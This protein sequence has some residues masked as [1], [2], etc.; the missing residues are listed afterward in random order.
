LKDL[1]S[2]VK[3]GNSIVLMIDTYDQIEPLNNWMCDFTRQLPNN[4]FLVI[5]TCRRL[6][7]GT[8]WNGFEQKTYAIKMEE[9]KIE[10]LRELINKAYKTHSKY[11]SGKVGDPDPKQVE[12]I[13]VFARGIPVIAR[14]VVKLWIEHDAKNWEIARPEVV[15]DLVQNYLMKNLSDT[16]KDAFKAA[17]VLRYFNIDSLKALIPTCNAKQLFEE[18]QKWPFISAEK[19]RILEGM[20]QVILEYIRFTESNRFQQLQ[21]AALAYYQS[22]LNNQSLEKRERDRLKLEILY[23]EISLNEEQGLKN[24]RILLKS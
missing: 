20:R 17:A 10:D 15:L 14:T 19:L 18:L 8:Y 5:A 9:M 3:S 13:A 1:N 4:V 22:Q 23:H 11:T 12:E 21:E 6:D 16:E 24:S 2:V 7:W